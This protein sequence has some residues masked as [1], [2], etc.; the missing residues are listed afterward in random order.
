MLRQPLRAFSTTYSG[1]KEESVFDKMP[2]VMKIEVLKCLKALE[3]EVVAK[4]KEAIDIKMI[5]A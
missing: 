4:E 5:K 1:D 3:I 2:E